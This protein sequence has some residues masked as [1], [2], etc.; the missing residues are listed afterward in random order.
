MREYL[1]T[2]SKRN[3]VCEVSVDEEVVTILFIPRNTSTYDAAHDEFRKQARKLKVDLGVS[4]L[5]L[6]MHM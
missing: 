1:L 6:V 3:Y 4:C 2:L 5:G